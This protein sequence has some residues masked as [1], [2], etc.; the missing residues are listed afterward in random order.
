ML[1]LPSWWDIIWG[2]IL[3]VTGQIVKGVQRTVET[4]RGLAG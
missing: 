2:A 3:E 4:L 1:K